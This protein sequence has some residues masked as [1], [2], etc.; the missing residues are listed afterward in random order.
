M[1]IRDSCDQVS[2][3]LSCLLLGGENGASYTLSDR[4][5][6]TVSEFELIAEISRLLGQ[7]SKHKAVEGTSLKNRT[8]LNELKFKCVGELGWKPSE[9]PGRLLAETVRWYVE[10]PEWLES[11]QCGD[12]LNSYRDRPIKKESRTG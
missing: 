12:Y 2:S 5:A 7:D 4:L 9:D 1:C 10:N 8:W 11:V 6:K 3:A